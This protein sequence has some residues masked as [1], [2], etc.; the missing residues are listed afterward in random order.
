MRIKHLPGGP[1]DEQYVYRLLTGN[2][3]GGKQQ[4]YD[5]V[6][7]DGVQYTLKDWDE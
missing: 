4:P 2:R 1:W 5:I 3:H 7:V 6:I